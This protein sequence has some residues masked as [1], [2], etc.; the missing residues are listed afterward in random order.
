MKKLSVWALLL[1]M[2][3]TML[4][5]CSNNE[6]KEPTP[7]TTPIITYRTIARNIITFKF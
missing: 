6:T 4:A 1:A 3:A 5:G 7:T 2:C